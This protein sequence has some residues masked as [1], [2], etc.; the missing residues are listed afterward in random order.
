M[1]GALASRV[2]EL[3]V[4]AFLDSNLVDALCAPVVRAFFVLS[5]DWSEKRDFTTLSEGIGLA[6][7][8]VAGTAGLL[9][10]DAMNNDASEC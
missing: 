4:S 1:I 7:T 3:A 5:N 10:E 8:A 9:V 2:P 6:A